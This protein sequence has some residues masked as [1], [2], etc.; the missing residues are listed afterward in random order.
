[1]TLKHF[2]LSAV[3]LAG[4]AGAQ[5]QA[6][7]QVT[8]YGVV[9]AYVQVAN[10]AKTLSRVQ[11][12]GL[13]GSRFGLKGSEDL[14]GGLRALF[15]I[16]S[17]INLD[18]GTNGQN[19]FWGR[20]A[21]VGLGSTY[22]QITLGRQYGSIYTLSSDFSEFSNGPIGA[23]T[24]VIGGFG[25]YEPVRGSANAATGNGGP[26]RINNS[27]KIESASFS[28]F[29]GGAVVGLGE[30][31][32]S[33]TKTR[34][35]DI[36]GRYTSGPLDAMVS[37]VDDRISATGFSVRTASGAAAYSFGD[38]RVTGGVISVDDRNTTNVD[39]EGY[40]IGG[41]YRVGLN[42]FK[43]QYVVNKL[44]D[45]DGKTQAIGAGYQY[46]LSKRTSLYS[47]LTHFKNEGAGYG[48]R[49]AS[50]LPADLTSAS[51]RNI[52]E[53]AAGIRHTF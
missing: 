3:A 49:W 34:V 46:D 10:G 53:L 28:G 30:V 7:N 26:A 9:D 21:F 18:D 31:A 20:Q 27:I 13:S 37:L 8:V 38:A 45:G 39:G 47:S 5:A 32:G 44:K 4:A 11:S 36:Y 51:D 40:W 15:T 23:S 22:G 24:S 52:T 48:D 33:T 12:G 14:G 25:G 1:M 43:A 41:D 42:L 6:S 2:A 50:S 35:A 16:E 19:A 29:K 17:G